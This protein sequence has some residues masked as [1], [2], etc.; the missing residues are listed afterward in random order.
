M[1]PD[2]PPLPTDVAPNERV[3]TAPSVNPGNPVQSV[4][5]RY[6]VFVDSDS[7]FVLQRVRLIQPD[8]FIQRIEGRRVIQA[9]TFNSEVNAR[10]QASRLAQQGINAQV[11]E[12]TLPGNRQRGYYA[13]VPG[14][15]LEVQEYRDRAIRLGISQSVVRIRDRP[16]GLHLA[17]GGFS[18]QREA[19]RTV[20]YLRDRGGMDARLFYNP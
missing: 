14:N 15:Q 11:T 12:G 9:G 2:L 10:Q 5:G 20:Q 4:R 1:N 6:R 17:V 16:L 19:E 8:A 13:I 18:N 3:Y 7:P